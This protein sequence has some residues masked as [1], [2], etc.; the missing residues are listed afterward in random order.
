MPCGCG[1][2]KCNNGYVHN[3][4]TSTACA[5]TAVGAYHAPGR[6]ATQRA[7]AVQERMQREA[8]YGPDNLP[9]AISRGIERLVGY[10]K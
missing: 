1:C 2:K 5:C 6:Q 4:Y 7:A 10:K 8:K 9:N 3:G